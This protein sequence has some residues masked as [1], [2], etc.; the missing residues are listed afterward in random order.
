MP[1]WQINDCFETYTTDVTGLHLLCVVYD[2]EAL[3]IIIKRTYV[4]TQK[5]IQDRS[6]LAHNLHD[7]IYHTM[8]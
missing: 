2:I 7:I 3:S 1:G 6:M 8:A 5:I 4:A